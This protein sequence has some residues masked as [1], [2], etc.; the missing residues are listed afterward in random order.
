[1]SGGCE[2]R[3]FEDIGRNVNEERNGESKE[4][5]KEKIEKNDVCVAREREI[6][7]VEPPN[8]E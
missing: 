5:K 4:K 7:R 2:E 3:R 8:E 6:H 1:M